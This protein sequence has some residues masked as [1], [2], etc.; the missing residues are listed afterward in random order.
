VLQGGFRTRPYPIFFPFTGGSRNPRRKN[1][2]RYS[3]E[4]EPAVLQTDSISAEGIQ[5]CQPVSSVYWPGISLLDIL[6]KTNLMKTLPDLSKVAAERNHLEGPP[7]NEEL[8][9]TLFNIGDKVI[10]RFNGSIHLSNK[11]ID[12]TFEIDKLR[13]K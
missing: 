4:S 5:P 11:D 3:Q 6:N 1:R 12:F 7:F 8:Y 13:L 2:K 9:P 10:R